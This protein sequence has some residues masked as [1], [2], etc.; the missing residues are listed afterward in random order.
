MLHVRHM[1]YYLFRF[2]L[3]RGEGCHLHKGN[4]QWKHKIKEKIENKMTTQNCIRQERHI[5]NGQIIKQYKHTRIAGGA[6]RNMFGNYCH[7]GFNMRSITF[8]MRAPLFANIASWMCKWGHDSCAPEVSWQTQNKSDTMP[9]RA[10]LS[11]SIYEL[12]WFC[13]ISFYI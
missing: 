1:T 13:I 12:E 8:T 7:R 5:T 10:V 9:Q 4:K 2:S 11:A 3:G 6:S